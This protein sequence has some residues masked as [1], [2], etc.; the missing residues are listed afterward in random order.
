MIRRRGGAEVTGAR[1]RSWVIVGSVLALAGL[2]FVASGRHAL[3][4][5]SRQPQDI[6]ALVQAESARVSEMSERASALNREIN[7]L[8]LS[9]RTGT[10][11]PRVDPPIAE[12]EGVAAG[13][14]PVAGPGLTVTLDDAPASSLDTAPGNPQPNDLVV[15]QQDLQNVINALWVGGAEAMTLQGERVTSTSAFRCSG[16]I[17][18]LHGKVFSPPYE[19]TVIGDQEALSQALEDDK[20]VQNYRAYVDWVH[21]GWGVRTHD[22]VEVPASQSGGDLRYARV[23]EGTD[24]FT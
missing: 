21:L 23:P 11:V 1:V 8:T 2:L 24:V 20:G 16:N 17:L 12:W 14:S 6:A 10:D 9:D 18:L 5:G 13:S 19:V 15:H 7:A 22:Q 3:Q 4:S